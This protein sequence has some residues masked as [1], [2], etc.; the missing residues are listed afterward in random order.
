ML[1]LTSSFILL[2]VLELKP[3]LAQSVIKT[4]DVGDTPWNVEYNPSNK[5]IYVG[6]SESNHVSVINSFTNTV[7][8]TIDVSNNPSVL[9]YNPSNGYI[10]VSSYFGDITVISGSKVI[11]TIGTPVGYVQLE[12]NPSNKYIYVANSY[13]LPSVLLI[14]SV[15]NKITKSLK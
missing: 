3:A 7:I 5:A 6:N 9:M 2:G 15:T 8:K 4:I 13:Y 12:Y 14:N 11:K 1:I 10:Y